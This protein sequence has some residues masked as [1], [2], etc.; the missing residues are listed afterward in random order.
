M[1]SYLVG[2]EYWDPEMGDTHEVLGSREVLRD[3]VG[4]LSG[5]QL[6]QLRRADDQALAL[7]A[8]HRGAAQGWDIAMLRKTAELIEAERAQGQ[9]RAA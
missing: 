7:V 4:E 3:R 6:A 8:A 1:R 5:E 9:R 2:I